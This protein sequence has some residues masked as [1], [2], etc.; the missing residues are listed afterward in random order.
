MS[1]IS[2]RQE[3]GRITHSLARSPARPPPRPDS[4]RTCD[5]NSRRPLIG[6]ASPRWPW[7]RRAC[8]GRRVVWMGVWVAPVAAACVLEEH[9]RCPPP[10]AGHLDLGVMKGNGC[11]FI[12]FFSVFLPFYLYSHMSRL[13]NFEYLGVIRSLEEK[14]GFRVANR[15]SVQPA[16]SAE[17]KTL[18]IRRRS[19]T[20]LPGRP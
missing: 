16:R 17:L 12:V 7:R 3:E 6:T 11:S 13:Y 4:G 10:A 20:F 19:C 14:T 9:P 1:I 5:R 15:L 8:L 18:L 2:D